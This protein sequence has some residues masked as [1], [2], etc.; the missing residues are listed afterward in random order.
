MQSQSQKCKDA[1][2]IWAVLVRLKLDV[3]MKNESNYEQ[4]E[5]LFTFLGSEYTASP[6][7]TLI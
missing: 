6:V 1:L 5:Q 7:C 3:D 2:T 4:Q